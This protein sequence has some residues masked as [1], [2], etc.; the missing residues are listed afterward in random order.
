MAVVVL[1]CPAVETGERD[2]GESLGRGNAW[3]FHL[4]LGSLRDGLVDALGALF[5]RSA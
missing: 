4:L 1:V 2:G 5:A 3:S